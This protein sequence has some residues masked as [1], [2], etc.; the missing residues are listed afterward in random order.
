M[1]GATWGTPKA[2]GLIVTRVFGS[3][4]LAGLTEQH[5]DKGG[6]AIRG[7]EITPTFLSIC[8]QK[9]NGGGLQLITSP[10]FNLVYFGQLGEL[11][12]PVQ[13][14]LLSGKRCHGITMDC[15]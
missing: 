4:I 5:P 10:L 15:F 8:C 2:K 7:R 12:E 14:D 13:T 11:K 1:L 9:G 6:N 3:P